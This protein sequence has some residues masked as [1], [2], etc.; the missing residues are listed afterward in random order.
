MFAKKGDVFVLFLTG[1]FLKNRSLSNAG[2]L[3]GKNAN[4]G[5]EIFN[6]L[7]ID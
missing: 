3:Y 6:E 4:F 1:I 5:R 7:K 2:W